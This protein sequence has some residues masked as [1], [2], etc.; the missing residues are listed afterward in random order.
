MKRVAVRFALM[1]TIGIGAMDYQNV[2]FAQTA[3]PLVDVCTGLRVTLPA[4]APITD[5]LETV[6]SGILGNLNL[7]NGQTI[8]L[9]LFNAQGQLIGPSANCAVS[10][11]TIG[12][13]TNQGISMGGGVINGLGGTAGTPALAGTIDAI[14]IG[15]GAET[16]STATGA[17]AI[18]LRGTVNAVD[19]IA[20][21]RDATVSGTGGVAVGADSVANGSG[22]AALG[23]GA[24]AGY[25]NST[26]I[27]S[28]TATTRTNQVAIGTT[29]NT[30][31]M[32]GVT[33]NASRAAQVGPTQV[34]TTDAFGNIA[35]ANV[36]IGQM[37]SDISSLKKAT[38]DIRKE[39]RRGIAAAMAMAATPTPSA[40]GKTAWATNVASFSGQV[41]GSLAVAHR[42]D[43]D[44]PLI[45]SAAVGYSPGAP[46]GVRF[47]VA[48]EF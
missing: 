9:S 14:A 11:D 41:A 32:A 3:T 20:L 38:N 13:S 44:Y 28:G 43:I 10:A 7:L 48:G 30:Y 12:V 36:D 21:G 39:E 34:L 4:L 2:A 18:G 17:V 27:G 47:G 40:P 26:A 29:S 19:G 15:N 16:G 22:S 42:I 23:S 35:S 25:D 33:S 31:T 46:A 1:L 45:V 37:Q 24:Q 8:G 6:L 5:P